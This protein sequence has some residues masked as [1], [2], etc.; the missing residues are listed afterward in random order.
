MYLCNSVLINH[1]LSPF[2]QVQR[3]SKLRVI[4]NSLMLLP[5]L[6]DPCCENDDNSVRSAG[7]TVIWKDKLNS[8]IVD[9]LRVNLKL[10]GVVSNPLILESSSTL[11]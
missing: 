9:V 6:P 8:L 3:N 11:L 4:L 10:C 7:I 5:I 2:L 1:V